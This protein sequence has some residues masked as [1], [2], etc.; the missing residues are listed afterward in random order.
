[1]DSTESSPYPAQYEQRVALASG[2]TVLFRP[3]RPG[4]G[5]LILELFSRLSGESIF[6]RFLTHLERLQ[7]AQL[8]HLVRIDYRTHFCLAAVILE[9]GR[10]AMIGTSRFM[11]AAAR[12]DR[13]ELTVTVR[14]DWQGR[15]IGKM[16]ASRVVEIARSRGIAAVEIL[17]DSRNERMI[18]LFSRLGYPA[19]YE[20]SLLDVCDR[21]EIDLT[22][23]KNASESGTGIPKAFRL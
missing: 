9:E 23:E 20:T 21:M 3:I 1:M 12:P 17:I 19:R 15:G 13:A 8:R 7:P 16:L 2:Q 6:Y 18:R 5:P 11:V 10:E 22:G 14:D 4:D